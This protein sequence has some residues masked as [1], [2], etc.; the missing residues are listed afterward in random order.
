VSKLTDFPGSID[1]PALI[2]VPE[3]I[4]LQG[5]NEP[6]Q[7]GKYAVLQ[8]A[9]ENMR[10]GLREVLDPYIRMRRFGTENPWEYL[11]VPGDQPGTTQFQQI[12]DPSD[13]QFWVIRHWRRMFDPH[14]EHALEIADPGLTPFLALLNP[15]PV[16]SGAINSHAILNWIDE[17]WLAQRR[18]VGSK[19]LESIERTWQLLIDFE[20]VVDPSLDFIKKAIRDFTDLKQVS[21]RKPLY[22]VGLFSIIEMLLTTQQDTTTEKSLSHQLREK[23]TLFGNRFTEPIVLANY[24]PKAGGMDFKSFVNNLYTYRSKVAHGGELDFTKGKLVNLEN[25][26]AVCSFLRVVVRKLILQ[27]VQEPLLF[28]DLKYC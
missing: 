28:H 19:Q 16:S 25:H 22:V 8:R 23:L 24:F 4:E 21:T 5:L 26:S 1:K 13:H 27:A 20:S 6:V 10:A 11:E 7:I 15:S 14:L 18:T 17:N 3:L 12:E 2:F 9:Q